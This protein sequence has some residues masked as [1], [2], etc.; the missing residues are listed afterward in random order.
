MESALFFA[1]PHFLTVNRIHFTEKC[2]KASDQKVDWHFLDRSDAFSLDQ[3]IVR[4][5]GATFAHDA[6]AGH[7]PPRRKAPQKRQIN[8]TMSTDTTKNQTKSGRPSFQ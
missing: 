3:S 2:S 4:E 8:G 6:L 1:V 5:T 7:H